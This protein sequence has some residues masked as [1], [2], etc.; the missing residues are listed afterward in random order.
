CWSL[1]RPLGFRDPG[2]AFAT[3]QHTRGGGR[4]PDG[5][6]PGP[7]APPGPPPPRGAVLPRSPRPAD[8]PLAVAADQA[9]S[10]SPRRPPRCHERPRRSPSPFLL[11]P[12]LLPAAPARPTVV[13]SPARPLLRATQPPPDSRRVGRR[14]PHGA[15]PRPPSPTPPGPSAPAVRSGARVRNPGRGLL[16]FLR[17]P[18]EDRRPR[19]EASVRGRGP[20]G[21]RHRP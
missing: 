21:P 7:P 11:L 9:L 2:P 6:R 18:A 20:R 5:A 16:R 10:P 8:R 4:S 14:R 1:T 3:P 15:R 17:G 13:A 12:G 19:L